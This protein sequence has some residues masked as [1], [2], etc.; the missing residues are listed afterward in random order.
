M[1][2]VISGVERAPVDPTAWGAPRH[3]ILKFVVGFFSDWIL[4]FRQKVVFWISVMIS[5]SNFTDN[6]RGNLIIE[7]WE[8]PPPIIK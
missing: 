5:E 6:Y 1:S 3:K 7:S 8:T 4:F 2:L